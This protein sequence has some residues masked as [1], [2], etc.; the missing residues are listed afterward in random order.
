[1]IAAYAATNLDRAAV[2]QSVLS[3][4]VLVGVLVMLVAR[5][6]VVSYVAAFFVI[7]A[8]MDLPLSLDGS[9]WYAARST[10][11]AAMIVAVAL[12]AFYR[13]LGGRSPF[14]AALDS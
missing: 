12:W 2:L 1:V 13:S 4:V 14:G 3:F 7:F 10:I 9:A 5:F 8:G 6:G 11:N